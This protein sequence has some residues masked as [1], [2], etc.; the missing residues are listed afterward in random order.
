MT[1]AEMLELANRIA[2]LA[3]RSSNEYDRVSCLEAATT[4]RLAAQAAALGGEAVQWCAW[5]PDEGF[6]W[7]TRSADPQNV[8]AALMRAGIAGAHGWTVRPLYAAPPSPPVPQ[9]VR[10]ALEAYASDLRRNPGG[11]DD[12]PWEIMRGVADSLEE[13]LNYSGG[14]E[15]PLHDEY[16]MD[17]AKKALAALDVKPGGES[18]GQ[19]PAERDTPAGPLSSQDRGTT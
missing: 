2:S 3:G 12:Y 6:D 11:G 10:E 9:G 17:R 4:L 14:A 7:I 5:H 15:S 8:A 16:V 13:I 19:S 1:K 18:A